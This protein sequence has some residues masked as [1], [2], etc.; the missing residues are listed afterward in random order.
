MESYRLP[1]NV[2]FIQNYAFSACKNL[3]SLYLPDD[4]GNLSR[5]AL[6]GC[7]ALEELHGKY[8]MDDGRSFV[9]NSILHFVL[10]KGLTVYNSP[11]GIEWLSSDSFNGDQNLKELNI[12]E[13]VKGVMA[14]FLESYLFASMNLEVLNLPSTISNL[15]TEPFLHSK[16]LKSLYIKSVN[17]PAVQFDEV[18]YDHDYPSLTIYVPRESLQTYLNSPDWSCMKK[19]FKGYDFEN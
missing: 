2:K 18:Y 12:G 10:T 4:L 9:S 8:I 11:E 15:G 3:K 7:D 5:T 16:S 17:P 14:G 6:E 19:Y 13:G 1:E